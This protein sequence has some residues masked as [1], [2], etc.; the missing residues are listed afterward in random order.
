[1]LLTTKGSFNSLSISGWAVFWGLAAAVALAFYTLQ[2]IKLLSKWGS[3]I[4]V[5][6]GM[7]IAGFAFSFVHLPW[8]VEHTWT[9]ANF[10]GFWFIIVFGTLIPFYYY[11]ESLHY[12]RASE[13]SLI[14]TVEP[15]TAVFVS[16]IW[17]G[18]EFGIMDWLGTISIISTL[19]ILSLSK[20]EE[21]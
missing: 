8:H 21:K 15:L 6:W 7:L 20:E 12:L 3:T 1:F 2:P 19:A 16:I 18:L 5:G 13:T 9:L 10:S 4:V 17:L 11:L 14:A